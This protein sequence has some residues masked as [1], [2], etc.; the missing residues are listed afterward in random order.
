[1]LPRQ[2]RGTYIDNF[3]NLQNKL[4]PHTVCRF[5]HI[6]VLL[7]SE[8]SIPVTSLMKHPASRKIWTCTICFISVSIRQTTVKAKDLCM[9]WWLSRCCCDCCFCGKCKRKGEWMRRTDDFSLPFIFSESIR[10]FNRDLHQL[11]RLAVTIHPSDI[12]DAASELTFSISPF[13]STF[14]TRVKKWTG[15][16]HCLTLGFLIPLLM[17]HIFVPGS[18]ILKNLEPQT[19]QKKKYKRS[20]IN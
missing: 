16:K 10:K 4:P 9:S 17:G 8:L 18:W 6:S 2:A 1:M 7:S 3:T 11:S 14:C 13:R 20:K 15:P 12:P 19:C 5:S